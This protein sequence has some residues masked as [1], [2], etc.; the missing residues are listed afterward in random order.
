MDRQSETV[1]KS[2]GRPA[3]L[4][5]QASAGGVIYRKAAG[6]LEIVLVSVRDGTVWCLPKGIVDKGET[7]EITALREV[8]EETGLEGRIVAPL[9]DI[10]YWYY[11]SSEN[12]KCRKT[13]SFFLMEYLGGDTADHDNEVDSADWFP[14]LE[15][16]EKVSFRGDRT[17]V[18][19]AIGM[20][21]EQS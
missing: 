8:R 4:R 3:S 7:P 19:R 14:L 18:D 6:G 12:I 2:S 15:A 17:I 11:V 13:V 21:T 10:S 16:V 1:Q 20:L 9:G 5:K